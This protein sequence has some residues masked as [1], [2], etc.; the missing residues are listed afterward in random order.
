MFRKKSFFCFVIALIIVSLFT[1][2]VSAVEGV[3]Y[4]EFRSWNGMGKTY[5]LEG[6][7]LYEPL[8]CI[9]FE[10]MGISPLSGPTDIYVRNGETY[11]LDSNNSRVIVLNSD[12]SFKR[13]IER[14][15][16]NDEVLQFAG[17]RGL[18]VAE[19]GDLYI[20]DTENEQI[21][22]ADKNGKVLQMFVRPIVETFPD[23]LDF[24]P[25]KMVVNEYGYLFVVCDG[26]Y[27]G[28]LIFDSNGE[29]CNF[30]GANPTRG[31]VLSTIQR[32]FRNLFVSEAKQSWS[33]R[34]L[35]Y[36]FDDITY[37]NGFIYTV[38]ANNQNNSG[39]VRKLSYSGQNVLTRGKQ[40]SD[41]INF[42]TFNSVEVLSGQFEREIF[43][44]VAVDKQNFIYL[45]DRTYGKVMIYDRDCQLITAIG[46]GHGSGSQVGT[47]ITACEVA[48]TDTDVL[49]LDDTTGFLTVFRRNN[50]GNTVYEALNL[51]KEGKYDEAMPLWKSVLSQDSFMQVAYSGIAK[52]HILHNDYKQ[53]MEYA[54]KGF[55][56]DV[57]ENAF[58]E[59]RR[60]FL[61]ESLIYIILIIL[62]LFSALLWWHFYQKK[63][64]KKRTEK[65]SVRI[66]TKGWLHPINSFTDMK[67]KKLTTT[68]NY[69]VFLISSLVVFIGW[70]LVSVMRVTNG[71]FIYTEYNPSTYNAGITLLSTTGIA[72]LWCVCNWGTCTLFQG[73][74][75]FCEITTVTAQ[76][77]IPQ[78]VYGI[79]YIIGSHL[80][81]YSEQWLFGIGTT[82]AWVATFAI[83]LV[84][85]CVIHEYSFF[86]A[87][88]MSIVTVVGMLLVL[89]ILLMLLTLFQDLYGFFSGIVTEYIYRYKG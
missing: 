79:F 88:V 18:F 62:L 46:G 33:Q 23:N 69:S 9:E 57:Y 22:K 81:V 16:H 64:P 51:D 68:G 65:I 50:F 83:L 53:A 78:I 12:Y 86:R 42:G 2:N 44:S 3:P 19:N 41:N 20:A 48:V 28:A 14:F 71:G 5:Y 61:Q 52:Y 32:A 66:L 10:K 85:M 40:S 82:V 17:A 80:L 89:F 37:Q 74:G 34:T 63:H 43:R 26:C 35:P 77:L 73:K 39:Q 25:I 15:V 8:C 13:V 27:Y 56:R 59:Y 67:E 70:F 31:S 60:I 45:L 55:N 87:I 72:V 58:K 4:T 49:V 1:Q 21:F 84:G 6:K 54:R 24:K 38:T 11:I 29:F 36:S 76:A 47:F 30:Y 75:N 7:S